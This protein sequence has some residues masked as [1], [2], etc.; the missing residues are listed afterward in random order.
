MVTAYDCSLIDSLR[1]DS[2]CCS[3]TT[4]GC[5]QLSS[6]SSAMRT[7]LKQDDSPRG[8]VDP[9]DSL[10][11]LLLGTI[12]P[13]AAPVP[14]LAQSEF[15]ELAFLVV[16]YDMQSARSNDPFSFAGGVFVRENGRP[17]GRFVRGKKGVFGEM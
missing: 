14:A 13:G 5:L 11:P 1:S 8:V 4:Y 16:E 3:S 9:H 15:D 17:S 7:G 10:H 12:F 6:P 2:L